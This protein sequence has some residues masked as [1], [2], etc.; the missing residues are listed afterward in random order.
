MTAVNPDPHQAG[1]VY[2]P[3]NAVTASF[4]CGQDHRGLLRELSEAG[5]KDERI[6]VFTGEKGAAQMDVKGEN[7]G[8]WVK[9][10]LALEHA[11]ADEAKVHQ[12][13]DELL[14]SGGSLVVA[15]TDGDGTKKERAVS[16]FRGHQSPEVLYWGEW[17]LERF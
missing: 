10:R 9:F 11:F 12:G 4:P 8:A 7:H 13:T 6:N 2:Q 1:Y 15:F 17:A 3:T 16:I 14:R 5:F